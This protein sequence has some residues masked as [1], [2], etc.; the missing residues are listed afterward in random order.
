M[1]L[2]ALMATSVSAYAVSSTS[3]AVGAWVCACCNS[4]IPVIFGIR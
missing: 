2:I 4:S 1:S 3:L